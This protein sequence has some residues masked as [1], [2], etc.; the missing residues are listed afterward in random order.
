MKHTHDNVLSRELVGSWCI[1]QGA[2]PDALC[3]LRGVGTA[4]AQGAE[5]ESDSR[6]RDVCV[7]M[8]DS[9]CCMAETNETL[10][11]N[12]PPIK[13]LYVEKYLTG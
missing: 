10:V 6:R 3:Q 1:P 9:H 5:W 4:G 13:Q 12:Y 7:L 8:T 2:Q 11:N